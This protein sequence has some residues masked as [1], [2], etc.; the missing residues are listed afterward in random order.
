M[1]DIPDDMEETYNQHKSAIDEELNKIVATSF[2]RIYKEDGKDL[3]SS[4]ENVYKN[5]YMEVWGK[6][7]DVLKEAIVKLLLKYKDEDART[8]KVKIP[9]QLEEAYLHHKNEIVREVKGDVRHMLEDFKY[10]EHKDHFHHGEL[11][12][13]AHDE[14]GGQTTPAGNE[15]NKRISANP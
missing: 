12:A 14:T 5:L 2:R 1:L 4:V 9:E 11:S 13:A 6:Q 3:K 10:D 8:F 7:E 15:T